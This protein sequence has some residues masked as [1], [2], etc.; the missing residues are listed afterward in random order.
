MSCFNITRSYLVH[1]FPYQQILLHTSLELLAS[2]NFSNS[3]IGSGATERNNQNPFPLT[4]A[5]YTM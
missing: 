5:L 1:H 2:N 3:G 4:V